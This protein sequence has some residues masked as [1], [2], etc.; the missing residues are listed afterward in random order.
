MRSH[1]VILKKKIRY[2]DSGAD[3][4]FWVYHHPTCEALFSFLEEYIFFL[5]NRDAL[6]STTSRFKVLIFPMVGDVRIPDSIQTWIARLKASSQIHVLVLGDYEEDGIQLEII[7]AG[8]RVLF[9]DKKQ[10]LGSV[11]FVDTP[12]KDKFKTLSS[13]TPYFLNKNN[14]SAREIFKNDYVL[15]TDVPKEASI[16]QNPFWLELCSLLGAPPYLKYSVRKT[17]TFSISLIDSYLYP[18]SLVKLK[19]N[20]FF[21]KIFTL[22]NSIP[23][24]SE[25]RIPFLKLTEWPL[26]QTY[27]FYNNILHLDLRGNDIKCFSFLE[28]FPNLKKLNIGANQLNRIPEE[29][30]SLKQLETLF[31]YKNQITEIPCELASLTSLKHLTL[32]RNLI[33][34]IPESIRNCKALQV[35]NIGGNPLLY[36][37]DR[38]KELTQ[39]KKLVLSNCKLDTVP[40]V[41]KLLKS[42]VDLSKNN[43]AL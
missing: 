42:D 13:L 15:K 17:G 7:K 9:A 39:L 43:L 12:L 25:L 28:D 18:K 21:N 31:A 26:E 35:L 23:E 41:V 11:T 36:I 30:Y 33:N 16:F 14:N 8:L 20:I 4:T 19:T 40:D 2:L 27:N 1:S 6:P 37:S 38:L 5:K 29:V 34:E 3:L 32:Y 24:V 22:L 10:S